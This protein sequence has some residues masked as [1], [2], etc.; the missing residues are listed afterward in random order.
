MPSVGK[1]WR[2]ISGDA[3]PRSNA[4][5][6]RDCIGSFAVAFGSAPFTNATNEWYLCLASAIRCWTKT[7]ARMELAVGAGFDRFTARPEAL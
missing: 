2:Q 6:P 1:A 7:V 5:T 4:R 3:S